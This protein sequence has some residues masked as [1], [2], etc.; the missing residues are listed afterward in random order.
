MLV[1]AP[2]SSQLCSPPEPSSASPF[3]IR[4]SFHSN[5]DSNSNNSSSSKGKKR[6]GEGKARNERRSVCFG[7]PNEGRGHDSH[8]PKTGAV[9]CRLTFYRLIHICSDSCVCLEPK[10]GIVETEVGRISNQHRKK[11][12]LLFRMHVAHSAESSFCPCLAVRAPLQIA[13]ILS[14]PP[15]N[16][17]SWRIDR[18]A[19]HPIIHLHPRSAFTVMLT[20]SQHT[21]HSCTTSACEG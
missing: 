1:S 8:R 2:R 19:V 7:V 18:P 16:S 12:T 3:V 13:D 10:Q 6:R 14:P 11:K 20:P 9:A 4:N 5:S 17:T 21:P 15:R